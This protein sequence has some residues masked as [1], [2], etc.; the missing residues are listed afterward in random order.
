[1]GDFAA[2]RSNRRLSDNII[3]AHRQACERGNHMLAHLLRDALVIETTGF[4]HGHRDRRH[5]A[6]PLLDALDRHRTT[7]ESKAE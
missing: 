7:F 1:M 6:D 3:E 5:D 2:K 4:G